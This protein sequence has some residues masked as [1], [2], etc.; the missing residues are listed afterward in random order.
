MKYQDRKEIPTG[1]WVGRTSA[2]EQVS[3][4]RVEWNLP[5]DRRQQEGVTPEK[6]RGGT[7][8]SRAR[9]LVRLA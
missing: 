2:K 3:G 5:G 1:L 8:S 4:G 9:G 7:S 6:K